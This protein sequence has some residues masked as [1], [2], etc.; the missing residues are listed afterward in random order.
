MAMTQET[1]LQQL[2][3][4]LIEAKN[5]EDLHLGINKLRRFTVVH[6]HATSLNG[7]ITSYKGISCKMLEMH[8]KSPEKADD[9]FRK[10][11]MNSR[12]KP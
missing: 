12:L 7:K 4:A 10:D 5:S 2:E 8:G 3:V 6:G 11:K 1:S 9:T